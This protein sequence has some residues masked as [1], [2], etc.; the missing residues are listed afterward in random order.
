MV[1]FTV[2]REY[3]S[4]GT[5]LVGLGLDEGNLERLLADKP[6]AIKGDSLDLK[7]VDI[8]IV[9]GADEN[10]VKERL[11]AALEAM[12]PDAEGKVTALNLGGRL[13]VVAMPHPEGVVWF[14][15]LSAESYRLLRDGHMLPFRARVQAE[16]GTLTDEG[17]CTTSVEVILFWGKDAESMEKPFHAAG[18][19][20]PNTKITRS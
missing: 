19:I 11:E 9:A 15:G 14:V 12:M 2:P 16:D 10:H 17:S 8:I 6:I 13:Y 5:T 20:G 18:L 7:G 4:R 1:K 3:S